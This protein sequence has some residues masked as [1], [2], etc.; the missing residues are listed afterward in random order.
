M[1]NA[2][3]ISR[4]DAVRRAIRAELLRQHFIDNGYDLQPATTDDLIHVLWEHFRDWKL[5]DHDFDYVMDGLTNLRS[6]YYYE[7]G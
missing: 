1:S 7:Q 2:E 4:K 3:R 5:G 6:E